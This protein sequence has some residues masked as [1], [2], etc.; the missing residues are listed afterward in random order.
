M[1]VMKRIIVFPPATIVP[2]IHPSTGFT[3]LRWDLPV[4]GSPYGDYRPFHLLL[5][6]N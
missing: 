5:G 1:V 6:L 2:D 4:S 3:P